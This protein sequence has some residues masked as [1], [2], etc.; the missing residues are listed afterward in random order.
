MA[1][2]NNQSS[3]SYTSSN[4][5]DQGYYTEPNCTYSLPYGTDPDYANSLLLDQTM[6][7]GS[8]GNSFQPPNHVFFS[9]G[10][11]PHDHHNIPTSENEPFYNPP[12]VYVENEN[13][14]NNSVPPMNYN[15]SNTVH[16]PFTYQTLAQTPPAPT[17][18]NN[19]GMVPNATNHGC[20]IIIMNA[21]INLERLLSIVQ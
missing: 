14:A 9:S 16:S 5:S 19:A 3:H 17:Y 10:P 12:Y 4:S 21:N 20:V 1:G 11:G 6:N 8:N 2:V 7:R 13:Q 15:S 18:P